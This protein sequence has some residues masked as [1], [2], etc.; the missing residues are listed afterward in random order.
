[1]IEQQPEPATARLTL[2]TVV[3]RL[4]G[5]D[6][7]VGLHTFDMGIFVWISDRFHRVRE[8][9]AFMQSDANPTS[10]LDGA[11]LWLHQAALRLFPGS[12]YARDYR[13]ATH[14]GCGDKATAGPGECS[15]SAGRAA[16]AQPAGPSRCYRLKGHKVGNR[17]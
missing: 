7:R 13:T 4:Y 6:I 15:G 12:P 17:L 9:R 10:I 11:A 5:S 2:E 8:D 1:V 16:T 14:R 3:C